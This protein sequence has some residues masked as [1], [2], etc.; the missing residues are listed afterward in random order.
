MLGFRGRGGANLGDKRKELKIGEGKGMGS[1]AGICEVRFLWTVENS[2]VVTGLVM[3][4]REEVV[5]T[6]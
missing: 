2:V 6:V 3:L 4:M 1:V 5:V